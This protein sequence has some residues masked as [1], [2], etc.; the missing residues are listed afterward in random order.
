MNWPGRRSRSV[1]RDFA[2][3]ENGS[4]IALIAVS[5][6]ALVGLAA[7]AVDVGMLM[8]A[9][10]EAQRTADLAALAGAGILI[11]EPTN[12]TLAE[13]TAINFAGQNNVNG[14]AVVVQSQ[15][16]DVDLPNGLVRVRV[17]RST[18]RGNPVGTFFAR[19]LG[20]NSVD[21]GAVAAAQVFPAG[22]GSCLLPVALPDR[23]VNLGGPQYDVTEGD[24]YAPPGD[25]SYTGY[26]DADIGTLIVLKPAQGQSGGNG[27][28]S[29]APG[30]FEPGW[31]YLWTPGGPGGS[32][33]RDYV[34]G[35][36]DPGTLTSAGDWIT[37]KNG[38]MQAIEQD[39]EDLIAQDP[40]ASYDPVC[41]CVTG[42]MGM[43]S[44]RIRG[45]P[46][47]EPPSYSSGGSGANFQVA[48]FAG[49]FIEG[50]S[51]GPPGKRNVLARIMGFSGTDPTGGIGGGASLA[52]AVRLVE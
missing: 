46:V 24:Y 11:A 19:A 17:D 37:D 20:I 31:W 1:V 49:V 15:D 42:G 16:V 40:Y 32:Q 27:S 44:P 21:V 29:G 3:N 4:T 10:T 5:M 35:C 18:A 41:N 36:P 28:N 33:V 6:T 13:Q 45:V 2:R 14:Q 30:S 52:D 43:S 12:S 26:T 39:F 48:G 38:N 34:T 25:P 9:R 47:F 51:S 23:W 7:L 50:V 8:S 22:S